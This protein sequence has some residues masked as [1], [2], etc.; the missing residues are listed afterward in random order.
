MPMEQQKEVESKNH[1]ETVVEEMKKQLELS[2][3]QNMNLMAVMVNS[4]P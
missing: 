4:F 2:Y 3:G 1:A